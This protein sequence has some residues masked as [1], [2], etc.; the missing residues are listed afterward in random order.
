MGEEVK[1]TSLRYGLEVCVKKRMM[2]TQEEK[3]LEVKCSMSF[4]Q[5]INCKNGVCW[6]PCLCEWTHLVGL[7][8]IKLSLIVRISEEGGIA[9]L[10]KDDAQPVQPKSAA[11][12]RFGTRVLYKQELN[13]LLT[14]RRQ[15]KNNIQQ[16]C[17]SYSF[18]C[19]YLFLFPRN[20]CEMDAVI[21]TVV[22]SMT[23]LYAA[24]PVFSV[25]GFK[26]TVGYQNCLDR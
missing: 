4:S 5:N 24:I 23:S 16:S 20:D 14:S 22:N 15:Q 9:I 3:H 13:C 10:Q 25:L 7:G 19:S 11:G 12:L 8:L 1:I 6:Q 2:T 18:A 21:I 17:C 26:A